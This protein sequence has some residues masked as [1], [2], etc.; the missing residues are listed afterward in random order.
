[1]RAAMGT[2]QRRGVLQEDSKTIIQRRLSAVNL[3]NLLINL[4]W[5]REHVSRYFDHIII[6]RAICYY[7]YL[8]HEEQVF[9]TSTNFTRILRLFFAAFIVSPPGP[10]HPSVVPSVYKTS[11][12]GCHNIE[13]LYRFVIN[14]YILL[15]IF[16]IGKTTKQCL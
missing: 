11:Q 12:K 4:S 1:M 7:L 2:Q 8:Q 14:G 5:V 9:I 16:R 6:A 13:Y 15:T 3:L 10:P